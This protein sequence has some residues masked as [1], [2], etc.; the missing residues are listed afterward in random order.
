MNRTHIYLPEPL[1]AKLRKLS[2]KEDVSLSELIRRAIEMM[3]AAQ[4]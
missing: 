4:R 2:N 1:L 3:L